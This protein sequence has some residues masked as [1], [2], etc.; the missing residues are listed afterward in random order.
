MEKRWLG[1]RKARLR[2]KQ[3][4]QQV[5]IESARLRASKATRIVCNRHISCMLTL[6]SR[7]T[8]SCGMGN[9]LA[10]PPSQDHYCRLIVDV[11]AEEGKA[12]ICTGQ[13]MEQI[14]NRK[15]W[16]ASGPES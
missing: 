14:I 6:A 13:E 5:L 15:A 12:I 16:L 4:H 10:Y 11:L 1:G 2:R 3:T 8:S 7:V 9:K